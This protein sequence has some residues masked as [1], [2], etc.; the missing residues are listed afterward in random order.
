MV[1]TPSHAHTAA[2]Y[3]DAVS[4]PPVRADRV[5]RASLRFSLSHAAA[6]PVA[7]STDKTVAATAAAALFGIPDNGAA[8][9][10]PFRNVVDTVRSV[11]RRWAVT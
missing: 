10:W 1:F 2:V 7:R 11:R 5:F 9:R 8:R 6:T 3:R 4:L